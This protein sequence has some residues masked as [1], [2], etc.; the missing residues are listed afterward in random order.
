M[1]L[2]DLVY[3][4]VGYLSVPQV[5]LSLAME[6]RNA[7]YSGISMDLP[8]QN[9]TIFD[10]AHTPLNLPPSCVACVSDGLGQIRCLPPLRHS[11]CVE[12]QIVI[13][14]SAFTIF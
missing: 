14:S 2:A 4:H 7:S 10:L 13:C 12:R 3:Q 6:R 9:F 5:R 1:P 11:E 8:G